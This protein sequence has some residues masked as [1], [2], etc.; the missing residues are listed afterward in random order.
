LP[1]LQ[2]SLCFLLFNIRKKERRKKDRKKDR[3]K[4]RQKERQTERKKER[5]RERERKRE[6]ERER[7]RKR[8]RENF[9]SMRSALCLPLSYLPFV[10]YCSTLPLSLTLFSFLLFVSNS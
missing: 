5:E 9:C 7:E 2:I 4:E 8:E 3:Q 1:L 10:F 6:R